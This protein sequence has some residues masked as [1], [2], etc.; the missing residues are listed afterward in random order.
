MTPGSMLTVFDAREPRGPLDPAE[1][2]AA[3]A[4]CARAT[5]RAD[6]IQLLDMCGLLREVTP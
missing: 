1:R 2:A 3:L 5:S 6:A 4:I